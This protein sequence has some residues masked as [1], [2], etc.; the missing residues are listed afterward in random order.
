[1]LLSLLAPTMVCA[2]PGSQ[3]TAAEHACCRQM[4]G[5]CGSMK[6]PAKHSCCQKSAQVGQGGAV[7]QPESGTYYPAISIAAVVPESQVLEIPTLFCH[8]LAKPNDSPP[9]Y[10]VSTFSVLRI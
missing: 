8:P 5:N 4:K 9:G 10:A 2:L 3:M 1:M 6:M 7:L